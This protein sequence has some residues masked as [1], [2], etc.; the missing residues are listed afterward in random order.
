MTELAVALIKVPTRGT[1]FAIDSRTAVTA[2]HCLKEKR[3]SE[4]VVETI[5]L[6]F[7]NGD[8]R[9]GELRDGDPIEDWAVLQLVPPISD[10]LQPIPLR[11]HV[12]RWEECW[13]PGFPASAVEPDEFSF[14][15][16]SLRVQVEM[17]RAGAKRISMHSH[18]VG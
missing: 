8:K 12:E 15:P 6:E 7:L 11:R 17:R 10:A 2:W 1:A 14:Q 5:E 4:N 13:C 9:K 18:E 16:I 3:S